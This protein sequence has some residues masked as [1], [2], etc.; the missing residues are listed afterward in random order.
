MMLSLDHRSQPAAQRH[1]SRTTA[2]S[3]A[4]NP[5]RLYSRRPFP[6]HLLHRF[7][8]SPHNPIQPKPFDSI[9]PTCQLNR[10]N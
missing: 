7:N 10:P 9:A 4:L 2:P 8:Y 6:Q 5:L 1:H 3:C